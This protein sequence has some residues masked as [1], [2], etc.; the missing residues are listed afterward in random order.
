MDGVNWVGRLNELH[1]KSGYPLPG[2]KCESTNQGNIIRHT[3][4]VSYG[5]EGQLSYTGEVFSTR[6]LAKQAAAKRAY[7]CMQTIEHRIDNDISPVG[8]EFR[9]SS[10]QVKEYQDVKHEIETPFTELTKDSK[11]QNDAITHVIY[12]PEPE[13]HNKIPDDVMMTFTGDDRMYKSPV[14]VILILNYASSNATTAC[15]QPD[16]NPPA[17]FTLTCH[18]PNVPQCIDPQRIAAV[19]RE[20]LNQ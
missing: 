19:L 4:R 13:M 5:S 14:N 18:T 6:K 16:A 12:A 7:E 10:T 2:Y 17:M 20:E 9:F 1:Q 15:T 3:A 8:T 11:I